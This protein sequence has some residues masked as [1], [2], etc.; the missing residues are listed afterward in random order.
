MM[1]TQRIRAILWLPLLGPSVIHTNSLIISAK[2]SRR[3]DIG[4]LLPPSA[5]VP[6]VPSHT[7]SGRS[8]SISGH[9]PAGAPRPAG[10]GKGLCTRR[11]PSS[12]PAPLTL[13]RVPGD[14]PA[15]SVELR[16]GHPGNPTEI[17]GHFRLPDQGCS[18]QEAAWPDFADSVPIEIRW[19][20]ESWIP[21]SST[22]AEG[23]KPL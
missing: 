23:S 9:L 18:F 11:P 12:K 4:S 8:S 15:K 2:H 21:A 6:A 19:A 14:P 16:S 7:V 10:L 22:P 13:P 3:R 20:S 1:I 17:A 5:A